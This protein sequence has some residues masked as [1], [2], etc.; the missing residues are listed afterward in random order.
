MELRGI[1]TQFSTTPYP[2][3][4]SSTSYQ[5][6]P[7][8]NNGCGGGGRVLID[9]IN[10]GLPSRRWRSMDSASK[11]TNRKEVGIE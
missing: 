8:G 4:P 5:L 9:T 11:E 7:I 1:N 2:S 3:F 6:S 10:I